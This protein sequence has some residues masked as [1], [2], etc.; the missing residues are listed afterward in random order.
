MKSESEK[1]RKRAK[2][3]NDKKIQVHV[4]LRDRFPSVAFWI[5]IVSYLVVYIVL[6]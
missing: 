1:Y 3:M 6:K 4:F 5:P 2:I